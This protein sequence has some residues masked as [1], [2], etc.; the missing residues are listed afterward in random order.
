MSTDARTIPTTEELTKAIQ[1]S[2]NPADIRA[3]VQAAL[4]KQD[5]EAATAAAQVE[6]EK[7]VVAEEAV[8]VETPLTFSRVEVIGG[9]EVSFLGGGGARID[10]GVFQPA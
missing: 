6:A 10:Q 5:G 3:H 1:E 4:A 7:A 2:L 9:R 8:V